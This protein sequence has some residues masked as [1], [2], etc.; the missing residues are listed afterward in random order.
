MFISSN[1]DKPVIPMHDEA[2]RPVP[3]SKKPLL[4]ALTGET[5]D[6]PPFWYM[7]QA[8]RYLPE[9]REVRKRAG[10]FLDLCYNPELATE[11]TL[12][13]LRRF[14]MD[15]AILF[16]DILVVPH[17]LG[18]AVWFEEGAGPKLD[19]LS[20]E[21]GIL[22]LDLDHIEKQLS[23]VYE[24]VRRISEQL[25][26]DVALIG[27]AGAPWTVATY[28]VEGG[29]SREFPVAKA[30]INE[31]PQGF[32]ALIDLLVEATVK[33]LSAQIV[34]GVEVVQIF[35]SWAGALSSD[36]FQRLSVAPIAAIVERLTR[37]HPET[38][39]IAF[40]R[41]VGENY[42]GFAEKTGVACVSIDTDIAP[43]WAARELQPRAAI[44]GNLDPA[45]LV[46]GGAEMIAAAENILSAL[47]SGPFV[48]NLGH[49][50]VP[51]TPPEHVAALSNFLKGW[52]R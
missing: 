43:D 29:S 33:H 47:A 10:G 16:S 22:D 13:P 31:D 34:A 44:Q 39:V 51:E 17:G 45:L 48:F 30:W 6:R 37:T 38:P 49:G 8:G 46:T 35:D 7:R 41:G 12:Q 18:Q 11:V 1:S 50:I 40:P 14:D 42:K 26:E 15:A 9:Y 3:K 28:M 2:F 4:R 27:F 20:R 21:R 52:T 32:Q 19:A 5:L 36:E 25:S 24:T 23:P